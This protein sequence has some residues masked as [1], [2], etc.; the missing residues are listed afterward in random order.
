MQPDDLFEFLERERLEPQSDE[1]TSR[2]GL[3]EL[4]G[5]CSAVTHGHQQSE[6]LVG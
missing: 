6:P 4:E 1:R 3:V 2:E 5:I